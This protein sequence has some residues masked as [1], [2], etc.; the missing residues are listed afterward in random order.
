MFE[1]DIR[2][3]K[4]IYEQLVDKLK[5]RIIRQELKPDEKLPSVRTLSKDLSI[6][7]NTI[8]KAFR[9]LEQLGY[10]YTIQG[11]GNFVTPQ[12]TIPNREKVRDIQATIKK[13]MAEAIFLGMTQTELLE[14]VHQVYQT[15]QG[16]STD[17][18]NSTG[19]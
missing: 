8:Q 7:P 13:L 17:D 1:L 10:I 19:K 3:R 16:G 5:E 2:S 4:P 18:S 6:N 9:E 15:T 12:A 11:K 14:M